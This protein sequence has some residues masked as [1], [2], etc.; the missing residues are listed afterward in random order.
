MADFPSAISNSNLWKTTLAPFEGDQFAKERGRLRNSFA[1]F[2]ERAAMLANEIRKDLPDLTIHDITHLD[3]LWEVGSDLAGDGFEITP[4]E[5]YVLGGAFLLHD[6]AMSIAA[7]PGGM[8]EI[9]KDPR[10]SDIVFAEYE[11]KYSRAPSESE[12]N[13]PEQE[14]KKK[15]L[16]E[17][18][19]Q[20]HAEKAEKLAFSH[21]T[22]AR[23]EQLFLIEDHELRQAFGKAIGEIA[24]SHWWSIGDVEKKFTALIGTPHW[25]T[26]NSWTVNPLKLACILRA[27]D[28]AHIDARRAPAFLKAFSNINKASEEH[29]V[30]Q[31]KLNKPYL[32]EDALVFTSGNSF[33]LEEANSW[34]LCLET[35]KMIDRELRGIDALLSDKSLKRFAARRV[36][37]V[38][39]PERLVAYIQ[40]EEWLPINATIHISDLPHIIKSIGGEELYGN[41]PLVPLRELIQNSCDAVRARRFIEDRESNYGEVVVSLHQDGEQNHILEVRDNGT[42]MSQNVLTNFLL[43]FGTSFWSSNKIHEEFP[44]L[45]SSGFKATG[46][47]GIGFF[48]VFM[49]ASQVKITTRRSDAATRDTLVLEFGSGLNGRPILRPAKRSEQLKD[50]GTHVSLKLNKDPVEKG[51]ILYSQR[52]GHSVTL[53]KVCHKIAP[54][55]DVDLYCKHDEAKSKIISA[56]DWISIPGKDLLSRMEIIHHERPFSTEECE[57]FYDRIGNNLTLIKDKDGNIIG[58]ACI[59]LGYYGLRGENIDA[60]G[61]LCVGGLELSSL[62]GICGILLGKSERASRDVG[63]PLVSI[64][65]LGEWA[66]GQAKLVPN[67]WATNEEKASC[68]QNIRVCGGYTGNLPIARNKEKWISADEIAE[69]T[70]PDSIVI[71]DEHSFKTA[72]NNLNEFTWDDNVFI[73]N[74]FGIPVIFQDNKGLQDFEGELENKLQSPNSLM[75]AIIDS[76]AKSWGIS[77]ASLLPDRNIIYKRGQHVRI[78]KSNIG[79]CKAR[80]FVLN[81]PKQDE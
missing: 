56:N 20:I 29:W 57:K 51:G 9:I 26:N 21:Y 22:T 40:T 42:G 41:N 59:S 30:F 24:H 2:R 23:G 54:A 77:V 43:D 62:S 60:L 6:L 38:D 47:Y 32:K 45:Q 27:A 58:R 33:Q 64:D 50:G 65:E 39:L 5:A 13:N 69:L 67:A 72:I 12:L 63:R 76:I 70:L 10:W 16:F 8:N 3:A 68:A 66:T 4:T 37:G 35:L 55:L 78:G 44:G 36:A 48:S 11:V 61:T 7:I 19:R 81:K 73:T 79:E 25:V 17:I 18:L 28:A 31:E 75:G 74:S 71:V 34:W 53:K 52:Q 15:A 1:L 14:I 80:A 49:I 46:K